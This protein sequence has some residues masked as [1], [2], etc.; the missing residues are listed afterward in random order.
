MT[1]EFHQFVE[2]R[3]AI[4]RGANGEFLGGWPNS[5]DGHADAV[6]IGAR[7]MCDAER[8]SG[9]AGL[10][11]S[12]TQRLHAIRSDAELS[13]EGKLK[14]T[15]A[16]AES[17]WPNVAGQAAE[18]HEL[19]RKHQAAQQKARMAAVPEPSM[20]DTLHDLEIARQFRDAPSRPSLTVLEMSLARQRQAL[21]RTPTAITGLSESD[22][23]RLVG[24]LVDHQTALTLEAQ[25]DA[26]RYSREAVQTAANLVTGH[27]GLKPS[28]KLAALGGE[29]FTA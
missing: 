14:R 6:I 7:A 13:A 24:S 25:A 22:H 11:L 23:A 16:L 26:L 3:M 10:A 18:W 20:A 5:L 12:F 21:V 15:R 2:P 27:L 29:P 17:A 1:S 8:V 28:E 9:A 19:N 4:H